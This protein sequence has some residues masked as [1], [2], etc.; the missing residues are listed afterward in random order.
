MT[1]PMRVLAIDQGTTSTRAIAFDAHAR[2]TALARRELPQHYPA[3]AWVEHDAEDIWRDTLATVREAI[4]R[5]GGAEAIAALGITNQR[6]T[7]VVWERDS[8][9]PVHRAIVWQDRRTAEECARLRTAGAEALVRAKTGLLLDPYFSG[10]KLAWILDHV[11]GARVRAERGE[12]AFGTIDTFLL[13]RLTGGRVHATDVTNA[14]RTLLLDIHRQRWDEELLGLLRVPR[15]VLPEVRDSS[16]LYGATEPQ[17]FGRALTIAGIA[18][19]QQ[20]ALFGQACFTPGMAKSTYGTGCFLL[21]NT[22]ESAVAS[23]NRMLTT[24]AYALAGRTTYAMEGSIF[25]AGAAIKWLRDGLKVIGNAAETAALA[26]R[27]PDDHGVYLVPAFV[28]LGAP[29]WAPESRGLICG[30]TL[31]A[32][33]AHLARAALESVAFQTLDL[34]TA[35]ARDG[36]LRA[37]AIRVDGG[38]A[39][40]DWFC[41]FLADILE[42]RVERPAELETTALG[43]AFLAGLATG[44]WPSLDALSAT[45]SPAAAFSPTM[46]GGRRA[47][48]IAGWRVALERTLMSAAVPR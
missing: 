15:A 38:M 14:S 27:V 12:L 43:A 45:W 8:G 23:A 4:E 1:R 3:P 10:T 16:A 34:T 24:P 41:Q 48:L 6:E 26:A 44:V 35:M 36:A 7:T 9:R 11:P 17:L 46:D 2:V 20:A 33:P 13:W 42:A 19:D 21:L 28:G 40:N 18:G 47:R 25:I 31:D 30:L 39:A 32:S 22:G 37:Q 29:H 5:S